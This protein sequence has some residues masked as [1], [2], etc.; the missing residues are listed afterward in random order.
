MLVSAFLL[1]VF[2]NIVNHSKGFNSD[3]KIAFLLVVY[4]WL[5]LIFSF[6]GKEIPDM[7]SYLSF[8]NGNIMKLNFEYLFSWMCRIA[9]ILGLSF[10]GFL[11]IYV[12]LLFS[13]WFITTKKIF[14]DIHLVFMV[15]LPFMGIY[16]FGI[17]IRAG[18]GICLCYYALT[19]LLSNK[20]FMGYIIYYLIVTIGVLFQ[21]SMVVFYLLPLYVFRKPNVIFLYILVAISIIIPSINI[22]YFVGDFLESYINLFSLK[23][24]ISYTQIHA[25]YSLHGV[26]SLTMIKYFVMSLVFI[27]LRK[28]ITSKEEIYRCFL[29]IYITGSLLIALTYFISAGNR[30]SYM[31][32]FF[33]FALV[34]LLYE[35][36]ILPKR[37]VLFG[38]ILLSIVNFVNLIS[39]IPQMITY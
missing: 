35:N 32:F 13:L 31:F 25:N 1:L 10:N 28:Y 16:N 9:K 14:T 34:G 30:L 20:T 38:A 8:Y 22:Q 17:I 2:A 26:Y 11:F 24:F 23:R 21:N 33:E 36:S 37:I 3:V 12:S 19:Y 29:N 27:W 18:M 4:L 6:P 7:K 15:F 5:I 39:S